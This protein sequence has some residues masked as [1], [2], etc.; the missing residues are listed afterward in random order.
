MTQTTAAETR[1]D[2]GARIRQAREQQQLTQVVLA[3]L[4]G[5]DQASISRVEAG[6]GSFDS[7]L[8]AAKALGLVLEVS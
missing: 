6:A 3:D 4:A 8:R 5:I 7:Y 1:R 2:W